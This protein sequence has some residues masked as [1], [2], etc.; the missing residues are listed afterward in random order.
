MIETQAEN[1]LNALESGTVSTN[2]HLRKVHNFALDMNWLPCPV[3]PRKQWPAVVFKEKRGITLE[4]H[5][6]IIAAEVNPERKAFYQFCWHLGASQ[7]DIASLKGEAVDWENS[8][9]GFFIV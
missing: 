8:T 2:V 1:F 3:I 9:L 6:R 4:E 5:Q 7:G